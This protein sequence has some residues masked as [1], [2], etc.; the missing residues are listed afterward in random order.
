MK[1]KIALWGVCFTCVLG[2]AACSRKPDSASRGIEEISLRQETP[3][4][5]GTP[6]ATEGAKGGKK[7]GHGRKSGKKN[8]YPKITVKKKIKSYGGTIA[9]GES[10]YELYN[11]VDSYA[12]KYA[13]VVNRTAK[14][15]GDRAKVYDIVVPTSVGI[16]LPDNKV[17]SVNSSNQ[18]KAI[19]RI[20]RRL[21]QGVTAVS[22]YDPLMQHRNEYIFFR[23]DHH[24]TS[25]GAYYAY[26]QYCAGKGWE[27]HALDEYKKVNFGG[28]LGSFYLDTNRSREL[29]K[30]KVNAYY[31][32][33]NKKIQMTYH[34][35][36]G[37]KY[38]S[39]VICDAKNYGTQLKYCAFIAGDNPFTVIRNRKIKNGSRCI[40]VKESYG[41][42]FVPYLTDHYQ[43]VYVVDYRYW[44]GSVSRLVRQKKAQ[45]VIFINNIS[46]TRNA[47]LIGKMSQI[48]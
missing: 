5:A 39:S 30:D 46:M 41:N 18:K 25:L 1:R 23:T 19:K 44:K 45:D 48:Q 37:G 40:V 47:Y 28:Y 31:P 13:E 29:K 36:H 6:D 15:I 16:T 17:G 33:M 24:W 43:T 7:A 26:Q 42:A 32:V 3:T 14:K 27:P 20:Y 38:N 8:T 12:K 4:P 10:G 21:D 34:D 2:L 22:L 9:I 11:Y 35:E